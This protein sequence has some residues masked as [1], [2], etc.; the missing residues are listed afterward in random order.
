LSTERVAAEKA[1]TDAQKNLREASK[2]LQAQNAHVRALVAE[3]KK[4][5]AKLLAA[6]QAKDS[7][8]ASKVREL[9]K[10]LV[11]AQ[12]VA[13][14]AADFADRM[15][16]VRAAASG[17]KV[18]CDGV[19]GK[20]GVSSARFERA[21]ET[22]V[23]TAGRRAA[24]AED[25]AKLAQKHMR[26][27]KQVG[28]RLERLMDKVQATRTRGS[29][30]RLSV[31]HA[32]ADQTL[33]AQQVQV[34]HSQV[35]SARSQ[36]AEAQEEWSSA[37]Q[38]ATNQGS[39]T[40]CTQPTKPDVQ[41]V[42]IDV[43]AENNQ[44]L[45]E[46]NSS[47]RA[48]PA[49]CTAGHQARMVRLHRARVE[50]ARA[51]A[52]LQR[53][54]AE[55][56]AARLRAQEAGRKVAHLQAKLDKMYQ[57]RA[58]KKADGKTGVKLV[59]ISDEA[60]QMVPR[61]EIE[62]LLAVVNQMHR[63][64]IKVEIAR[65]QESIESVRSEMSAANARHEELQAHR[66]QFTAQHDDL[67]KRLRQVQEILASTRKAVELHARQVATEEAHVKIDDNDVARLVN[68]NS[69]LRDKISEEAM[70]LAK[71]RAERSR[72][73]NAH[74]EQVCI[75]SCIASADLCVM[76]RDM[77]YSSQFAFFLLHRLNWQPS[78]W[79]PPSPSARRLFAGSASTNS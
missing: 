79:P 61:A 21:L 17:G 43:N 70:L 48:Y 28:N 63:R 2:R 37:H 10:Q 60:Q 6:I 31:A 33:V 44:V 54:E 38:E 5:D 59:E 26:Q 36:V 19:A 72:F 4:Q 49:A 20:G 45:I 41:F 22:A 55:W 52:H 68:Q 39:I 51:R 50:V 3:T 58:F 34:A 7:Q 67:K 35:K 23:E 18:K 56:A 24:E 74:R 78:S 16:S 53:V 46:E 30:L 8:R 14:Q 64:V 25:R 77:T 40:K 9:E 12:R 29:V 69:A 1:V 71:L 73:V 76:I 27:L 11:V 32:A 57:P 66:K 62:E 15:C 42:P 13:S 47:K 65:Q 75:F